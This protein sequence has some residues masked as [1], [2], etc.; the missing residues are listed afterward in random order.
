VSYSEN[1]SCYKEFFVTQREMWDSCR[2]CSSLLMASPVDCLFIRGAV[3]LVWYMYMNSFLSQVA[4]KAET[5][6]SQSC[7]TYIVLWNVSCVLL[8]TRVKDGGGEAKYR[9]SMFSL[10]CTGNLLHGV[11]CLVSITCGNPI[12]SYW[13]IF[14]RWCCSGR[15]C[16][17]RAK[18]VSLVSQPSYNRWCTAA[19]SVRFAH[20]NVISIL[21]LRTLFKCW[22]LDTDHKPSSMS[23]C[24]KISALYLYSPYDS[25]HL[26][27][28]L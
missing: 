11:V 26:S 24:W 10:N 12:L 16:P 27:R 14:V 4:I 6:I 9:R 19:G 21:S 5:H 22:S 28:L 20:S 8:E 25:S 13:K 18:G 15:C 2:Q 23:I 7:F 3:V 1:H 17:I